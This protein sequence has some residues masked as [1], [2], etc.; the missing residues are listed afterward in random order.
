MQARPLS[1]ARQLACVLRRRQLAIGRL[2]TGAELIALLL[3]V[4]AL[5]AGPQFVALLLRIKPLLAWP[6]LLI[7]LLQCA[8][9]D[10]Q[11]AADKRSEEH[12]SKLQSP[13]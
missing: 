7:A 1:G 12:T 3:Q 9:L 4:R 5:L 11:L 8:A 6:Q 2:L 10:I 13:C